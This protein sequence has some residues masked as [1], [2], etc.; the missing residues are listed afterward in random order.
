MI[1][2]GIEYDVVLLQILHI[3]LAIKL[4]ML[5][6]QLHCGLY[7]NWYLYLHDQASSAFVL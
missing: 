1:S 5:E 4:Y 3:T 2:K 7:T 6:A